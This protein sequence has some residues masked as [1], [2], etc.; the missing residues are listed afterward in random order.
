L[1]RPG[2]ERNLAWLNMRHGRLV[3]HI[4]GDVRDEDEVARAAA[5]VKAVF[6]FAAQ[7][8]VTTSLADPRE[9]FDIN[10][11]GTIN[12]LD[13]VRVRREPVPVIFASTNKVYG[14]LADIALDETNDAYLPRDPAVRAKGIGEDRPLDFHT[15]YGCS[16]GAAD[17][18][19]LDYARS[20]GVPTAVMRMSCIYGP[21][22]MGTEDQGWVA[23]F[24]IRALDGEPISIYGDGRQ[25]R[26][27]LN[28][29]DAVEAYVSA[30]RRIDAVQGRAFNLGGGPANAVS[31]RQLLRHVEDLIGRPVELSF[32]DWRAGD[33]RYYVSDM[34]RAARALEL[35]SPIPWR[36]GVAALAR[37]LADERGSRATAIRPAARLR[38]AEALS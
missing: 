38:A 2:V 17:Q 33:Q 28:V 14:D 16:K 36:T 30:W 31:L 15:P 10:V 5:D 7:V 1:S 9:D 4:A 20:F 26:D 27:V 12:V 13:A 23:H 21:R 22:Q 6:H 19:V 35:R 8:A 37:W 34:S 29:A 3:T 24:L 11:R 18:Y 32:S 25:V